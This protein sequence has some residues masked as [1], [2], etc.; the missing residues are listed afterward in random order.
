MQDKLFLYLLV[1]S[2]VGMLQREMPVFSLISWQTYKLMS[3]LISFVYFFKIYFDGRIK[4]NSCINIYTF[5]LFI[6]I[7]W[8]LLGFR[9]IS[10]LSHFS[11]L[12]S[13]LLPIYPLYYLSAKGLVS[14]RMIKNS[15]LL[16]FA[17]SV[18]S[19]YGYRNMMEYDENVTNNIGY[20]FVPIICV[21]YF[22]KKGYYQYIILVATMLFVLSSA[23]RG[24][25]VCF[26]SVFLIFVY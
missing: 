17:M 7:I 6:N 19:F 5:F 11:A 26:L 9:I 25:I 15:L 1:F 21:L 18:F 14:D 10:D 16:F 12:L 13:G 23:K 2:I 24:G 20:Y 4:K 22:M 8:A 3:V